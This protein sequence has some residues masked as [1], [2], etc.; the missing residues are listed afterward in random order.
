MA[1]IEQ[2]NAKDTLLGVLGYIDSPFKLGVVV[3]LALLG[4]SG[5]M[6][7]QNSAF[8]LAAYDKNKGIPKINPSK[9]DETASFLIKQTK[10]DM[11]AIYEVDVMLNTRHLL[12]AYTKDG[13]DKSHDGL[14]VGMLSQNQDNNADLLSLYGG[15]IPCGGYTR[16]QSV[17]GLWYLQ[18]G[19][20]FTCRISVPETPGIFSGQITLGWK[21]P[22]TDITKIQD[23]LVI[24]ASGLV[25][26]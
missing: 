8:L 2:G 3:L 20:T 19:I 16:A 21:T 12:R 13:R 25:K 24:A 17:I 23:M 11:V 5:Y 26:K 1:D 22:P 10:A 9:L 18:Q 15:S 14:D 6:I 7:H 4:F